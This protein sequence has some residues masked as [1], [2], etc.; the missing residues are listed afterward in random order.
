VNGV[1]TNYTLDLNA[2]LT[3]VLSDGTNTYTYG[4]GRISQAKVSTAEYF[5]GDALGSV[6][7]LT[8]STGAVTYAAAYDPYGAVTQT[9]GAGQSAYGFTGEQQSGDL[10]YLRTRYVDV[11]D[12]RFLSRDTW[13]GNYNSPQSLNRWNYVEENPVNLTD[14]TGNVPFNRNNAV[15]YARRYTT[16]YNFNQYGVFGQG[17]CTNFVSQALKA[18][19]FPE[20]DSE[21][22]FKKRSW[23][24]NTSRCSDTGASSDKS[25]CGKAWALTFNLYQFLTGTKGFNSTNVGEYGELIPGSGNPFTLP[26]GTRKGDVVFYRQES[27]D[28]VIGGGLFN[29]AAIIVD[30]S[31][32]VTVGGELPVPSIS[33]SA[34]QIADHSGAYHTV[35]AINDTKSP[36][37]MLLIV[38]IPDD[39]PAS[40]TSTLHIGCLPEIVQSLLNVHH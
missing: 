19:G 5:L 32:P 38:H 31:G 15:A 13:N 26:A 20:D 39:I 24:W 9:S 16:T 8:D 28:F 3:Q 36:V 37:Q 17:D 40:Q 30:T 25:Y 29:H 4:I 14:P 10:V 33:G 6:R 18:G 21:W 22:Y 1:A 2:G 35:R 34:P 12:G 27:S 11:S 7:Q 23:Y